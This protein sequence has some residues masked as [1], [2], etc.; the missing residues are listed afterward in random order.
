MHLRLYDID[1]SGSRITARFQVGQRG[2]DGHEG[3]HDA[4]RDVAAVGQ[5]D[6]RIGHQMADIAHQ[7]QGARLQAGSAAVRRCV[8]DVIGEP[9]GDRTSTLVERLLKRAA[10]ET[11]PVGV[12]KHLVLTIDRGN[13]ILAVHDARHGRFGDHVIDPGR[14]TTPDGAAGID[15]D[16]H[17]QPVVAKHNHVR[18]LR[19]TGMAGKG[20][21][22]RKPGATSVTRGGQ[23]TV[24]DGE[25]GDIAPAALQKREGFIK[26]RPNAGDHLGAANRVISR[27]A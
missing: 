12:G 22:G 20:G 24:S 4:F 3:V 8:G 27:P 1:R 26:K 11:K 5:P 9:A 25:A 21:G 15:A 13:R 14:V 2:G 10:H 23:R 16:Q 17:M 18:G 7:H 19:V 6:G